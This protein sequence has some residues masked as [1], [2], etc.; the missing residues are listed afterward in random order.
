MEIIVKNNKEQ[1]IK[2]SVEKMI[3]FEEG[4]RLK[5]YRCTQG[6][7]TVGYGHNL[8]VDKSIDILNRAIK[9]GDYITLEEANLLFKKDLDNVLKGIKNKIPYFD[10]LKPKYQVIII[11][12]VFQMGINGVLKFK[13]TLKFMQLDISEK[14]K[15]GLLSSLFA[16]QTPNRANRIANLALGIIPKEYV[17]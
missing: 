11:N 6:F 3:A 1:D 7:L 9:I 8:D 10:N 5:A 14:V 12:M 16:K 2:I 17:F 4:L 13:N 15:T